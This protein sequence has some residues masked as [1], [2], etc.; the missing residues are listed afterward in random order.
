MIKAVLFDFGG[1]LTE[2]GKA[3][4][5]RQALADLYEVSMQDIQIDNLQYEW[6]KHV[7]DEDLVFAS[8]NRKYGKQVTPEQFYQHL[9]SEVKPT[10]AVYDLAQRLRAKGIKTGILS[11]VFTTSA[12]QLRKKGFYRD[13]E[14]IVLSCEE[15]YAKPDKE[16]YQIAI[17]KS[18]VQANEILFVD[19]Q[20]KCR[21]PAEELGMHFILATSPQQIVADIEVFIRQQNDTEL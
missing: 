6:R 7:T 4:F 1:V 3:G 10:P 16:L 21:P 14:P 15:G 2:S 9:N 18:G 5:V 8:L 17:K 13:F 12:E 11:N 19:D 20:E